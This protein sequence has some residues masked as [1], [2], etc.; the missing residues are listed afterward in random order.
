M[1]AIPS[2]TREA[3][4]A[5]A[6]PRVLALLLAGIALLH[7]LLSWSGGLSNDASMQWAQIAANRL[8]DWHPPAMTRLW[9]A[10]GVF[11][12]GPVPL[13]VLS[14]LLYWSGVAVLALTLARLGRSGAALAAIAVGVIAAAVWF[15][16]IGKDSLLTSFFLLGYG[17]LLR[18]RS[19]GGVR[20][21]LI[22]GGVL[23]IV[24]GVLMRHNAAFAAG[25]AL[26][27]AFAPQLLRRLWLSLLI[28]AAV[29][30]LLAV[31]VQLSSRH[32]FGAE[33]SRVEDSLLL[34]D[35]LGIAHG[36]DDPA[37]FGPAS[38]ISRN[39]VAR[40]Y[41]PVMWD[42][43]A[44]WGR[45]AWFPAKAGARLLDQREIIA[46]QVPPPSD[47]K[48]RW[49]AA[50]V[51]HPLAYVV[52]RT[53]HMNAELLLFTSTKPRNGIVPV[54]PAELGAPPRESLPRLT[55][56][57]TLG[58][59]F[60]PAVVVATAIGAFAILFARTRRRDPLDPLAWT[61]LSMSAA[62]LLYAGSYAIVGVATAPRY[63]LLTAALSGVALAA[64]LSDEGLRAMLRERRGLTL[65]CLALPL[66]A[67][68]GAEIGRVFVPIP[69]ST[70]LLPEN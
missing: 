69:P 57:Y 51:R 33:P 10:L 52:H 53:R 3:I 27:L 35:L 47:F 13:L 7:L 9:Q 66:L 34:F 15:D 21:G 1:I 38:R 4:R 22:A 24:C 25:P 11:G 42:T 28:S 18:A 65:L 8:N 23:L 37:V 36:A 40:C 43:M 14:I 48:A 60:I 44:P 32:V 49:I 54:T 45:C 2:S 6:A 5:F 26:I 29:T 16:P 63:F 50:V 58:V 19:G 68:A 39:D 59:V 46:G 70:L 17:L 56:K 41:S 67:I 31:G 30:A 62:G 64:A 12:P 55:A 61:A 20:H